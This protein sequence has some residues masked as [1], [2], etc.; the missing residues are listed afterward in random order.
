M[1]KNGNSSKY[2]ISFACSI[3]TF[4]G[5]TYHL[6]KRESSLLTL[7]TVIYNCRNKYNSVQYYVSGIGAKTAKTL[8]SECYYLS[9]RLFCHNKNFSERFCWGIF[10]QTL[11]LCN[12]HGINSRTPCVQTNLCVFLTFILVKNFY[13]K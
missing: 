9:N 3:N 1:S 7:V 5:G 11:R 8:C 10:V 4:L 6:I 2:E 13:I 12:I